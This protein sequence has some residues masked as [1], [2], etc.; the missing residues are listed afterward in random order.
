MEAIYASQNSLEISFSTSS[1]K[2]C[3]IR[4]YKIEI[5]TESIASFGL[6]DKMAKHLKE[7]YKQI[8]AKKQ[9]KTKANTAVSIKRELLQSNHLPFIDW[10]EKYKPR[11]ITD[12]NTFETKLSILQ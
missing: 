11:S 4:L 12:L 10:Q 3:P 5:F 6:P 7:L 1:L 9:G 8:E 2:Q